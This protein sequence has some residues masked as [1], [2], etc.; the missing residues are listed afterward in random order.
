MSDT[1]TI[2]SKGQITLPRG[3]R[4]ALHVNE[5]DQVAFDVHGDGTVTLRGLTT[6]PADQAWFW[7]EEW[8]AK[9]READEDIAAGRGRIFDSD[10][11]FLAALEESIDDPSRL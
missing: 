7:T 11:E 10:E 5:G 1:A 3:I 4:H 9:E 2:R 8:Q 6:I